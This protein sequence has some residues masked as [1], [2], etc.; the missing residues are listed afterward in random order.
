MR[1]LRKR[2]MSW[3]RKGQLPPDLVKFLDSKE[4]IYGIIESKI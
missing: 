1:R 4:E 2:P 3:A